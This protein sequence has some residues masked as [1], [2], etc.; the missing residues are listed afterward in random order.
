MLQVLLEA[1]NN[2]QTPCEVLTILGLHSPSLLVSTEFTLTSRS[3]TPW[4]CV[5]LGLPPPPHPLGLSFLHFSFL[6][7]SA[8]ISPPLSSPFPLPPLPPPHFF[9]EPPTHFWT[10]LSQCRGPVGSFLP[11]TWGRFSSL[12]AHRPR[13]PFPLSRMTSG[14]VILCTKGIVRGQK[15]KEEVR[16]QQGGDR[17]PFIAGTGW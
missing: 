2:F 1:P 14:I 13:G 3:A 15:P 5:L 16:L 9:G 12:N 6:H 11:V 10:S 8:N 4:D 17:G 7:L